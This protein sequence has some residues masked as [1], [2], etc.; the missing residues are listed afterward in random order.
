VRCA[1]WVTVW[2]QIH[3]H[4][5]RHEQ[6]NTNICYKLQHREWNVGEQQQ[7]QVCTTLSA[8]AFSFYKVTHYISLCLKT[9][10]RRETRRQ[11]PPR[12][13]VELDNGSS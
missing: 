13:Y 8:I 3:E 1:E 11:L 12:V 6:Y 9:F 4:G 7:Q 2:S 5:I 10:K